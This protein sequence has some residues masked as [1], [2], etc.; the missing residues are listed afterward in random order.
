M[1]TLSKSGSFNFRRHIAGFMLRPHGS[2]DQPRYA[3]APRLT[4]MVHDVPQ[5]AINQAR[6][7]RLNLHDALKKSHEEWRDAV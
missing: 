6:I 4:G 5:S 3:W 2:L 1:E 7:L